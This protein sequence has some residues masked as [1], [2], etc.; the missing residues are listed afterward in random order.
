M[1]VRENATVTSKCPSWVAPP[2]KVGNT[3]GAVDA[4]ERS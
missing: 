2:A 3:E 4:E 1:S